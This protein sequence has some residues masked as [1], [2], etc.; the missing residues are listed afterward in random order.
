MRMQRLAHVS[1]EFSCID[2][3]KRTNNGYAD[4]D[5]PAYKAYYCVKCGDAE[6]QRHEAGTFWC[7][8]SGTYPYRRY[9]DG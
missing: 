1:F 4:L 5:G 8:P 7:G 2:C 3:G 6:I 9:N